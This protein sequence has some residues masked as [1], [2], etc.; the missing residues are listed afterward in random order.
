ALAGLPPRLLHA[1]VAVQDS[2]KAVVCELGRGPQLW[3]N[4][5]R[6]VVLAGGFSTEDLERA[7]ETM[8]PWSD[9]GMSGVDGELHFRMLLTSPAGPRGLVVYLHRHR[10][11]DTEQLAHALKRAV[12]EQRTAVLVVGSPEAREHVLRESA[13]ITS[14]ILGLS[15]VVVDPHGRIGGRGRVPDRSIGPAAWAPVRGR[16]EVLEMA[17]GLLTHARPRVLVTD[18]DLTDD[19][20]VLVAAAGDASL[21]LGLP[22]PAF[23]AVPDALVEVASRW[24]LAAVLARQD[25]G[26]ESVSDVRKAVA[27]ARR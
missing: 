13:S 25:G 2:L 1:A 8:A 16:H 11:P 27:R 3:T 7:V 9:D 15:T 5:G 12:H 6:A 20:Q 22:L 21:V 19:A 23:D 18:L 10:K 4:S 26:V 17:S 24:P 14:T